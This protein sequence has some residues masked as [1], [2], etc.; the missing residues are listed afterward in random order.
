MSHT[1]TAN[2]TVLNT[3]DAHIRGGGLSASVMKNLWLGRDYFA[4]DYAAAY[5]QSDYVGG[6]FGNPAFGSYTGKS[7]ARLKDFAVR[8]GNG[9]LIDD[10]V[11]LTSYGEFGHHSYDRTLAYGTPSSYLE[12]YTHRY[13]GIGIRGQVCPGEKMVWSANALIGRTFGANIVVGLPAPSGFSARLGSSAFYKVGTSLD[14]AFALHLH[15]NLAADLISWK[16]GA[17]AVQP[18]GSSFSLY[19]PESRTNTT[20]LKAGIGY[21]F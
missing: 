8:Y 10:G 4:V 21:S 1:E 14:Y 7:G 16:Y 20:M 3:E 19:E 15:A 6:T 11:L 9:Y 13:F 2:G 18:P 5:G 12:T 17:S